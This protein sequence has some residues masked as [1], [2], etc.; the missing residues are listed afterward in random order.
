[1]LWR[2]IRKQLEALGYSFIES[3]LPAIVREWCVGNSVLFGR[4]EFDYF[5]NEAWKD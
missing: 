1:M 2:V 5:E 4:G 3:D